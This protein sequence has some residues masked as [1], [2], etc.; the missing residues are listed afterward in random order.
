MKSI[1]DYIKENWQKSYVEL[2]KE[3]G[4]SP[5]AIRG[6]YRRMKL[7]I[8]PNTGRQNRLDGLSPEEQIEAD[9]ISRHQKKSTVDTNKK[10]Q[11]LID[12]ND[13]L[14]KE[15]EASLSI[16]DKV[17]TQTIEVTSSSKKSEAVAVALAS[18]WHIEEIV[19]SKKVNGVN[20][21][22]LEIAEK[23]ATEFFQNTLKLVEKERQ[24]ASIETLILWLG[25]DF[26]SGNIHDELLENCSL[27][28][29]DAIIMAQNMIASGIEFLLKNSDIKLV[30]PCNVGNHTRITKKTHY[31]TEQGNSLEYLMYHNLANYFR[32]EKRVQ[33]Q[34]AESYHLY[35]KVF[36]MTLRFHHGHAIKYGGGIGGIYIS[37]NKALAQWQKIKRADLDIFGHFHSVKMGGNFF[38]NGSN[39]GYNAYALQ[40][41]ADYEP[42]SQL[43][44]LISKKYGTTGMFPIKFSK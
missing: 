25:G 15:L 22:N 41:K 18:D 33:F 19:Q 8:K 6:R 34:I 5:D 12:E 29:I 23:R 26:I 3:T 35:M 43:F 1:N 32:Q 9:K 31:S 44:F 7:P 4:L 10:Y 39:I 37:A 42:A 36:D 14:K 28:P 13:K 2:A 30:I 20:E 21:Y 24:H 17:E 11:M 27:R 16:K 40:I 38:C